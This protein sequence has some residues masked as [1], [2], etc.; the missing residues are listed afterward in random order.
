MATIV[1]EDVIRTFEKWLGIEIDPAKVK[2][3]PSDGYKNHRHGKWDLYLLRRE[4][5]LF[6]VRKYE[7]GTLEF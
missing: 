5:R 3:I 6:E 2:C 7:D 1:P 4:E